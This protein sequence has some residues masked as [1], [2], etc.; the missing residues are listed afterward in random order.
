M[1]KLFQSSFFYY[2]ND[3]VLDNQLYLLNFPSV[4]SV[5]RTIR[6]KNI[7]SPISSIWLGG[8]E[9]NMPSG[10]DLSRNVFCVDIYSND[11][12]WCFWFK[13]RPRKWDSYLNCKSFVILCFFL[14]F[15]KIS[16]SQPESFR[17]ETQFWHLLESSLNLSGDVDWVTFQTDS[18]T[19]SVLQK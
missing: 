19:D 10:E 9:V 2:L 16:K 6:Q 8:A 14:N 7:N 4:G 1:P 15:F 3:A 5:G 12:I 17:D 11:C 13:S 18:R